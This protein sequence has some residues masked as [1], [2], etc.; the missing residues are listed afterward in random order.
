MNAIGQI[1]D[2]LDNRSPE[3]I[4]NE[5]SDFIHAAV[6]IPIFLESDVY[7]ILFTQRTNRVEHHKGQIS[8]PGGS[9]EEKDRSLLDTALR[10]SCEEIGLLRKD[11][12]ILGQIDDTLTVASNFIVRPFVGRIPY[13]YPFKINAVEV[14]KIITVPIEI[15]FSEE[16]YKEREP[17]DFIDPSYDG[18]IYEYRGN[19]IWGA[20]ARIMENFIQ[21]VGTN[22][23]L[24]E[25]RE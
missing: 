20:T 2:I 10:E 9:I 12:E 1:K 15:F 23:D 21:I 8:F 16:A 17:L 14:A 11:V 3:P 18:P 13:P 5:N 22:L 7:K 6:L 19:I 25:N 24:P 4:E